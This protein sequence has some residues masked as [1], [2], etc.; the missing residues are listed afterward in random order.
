VAEAA[1]ALRQLRREIMQANGW[2]LRELYKSL[3]AP[4]ENRLRDA[5]DALDT[6]I[7]RTDG[8]NSDENILFFLLK[9][10]L[11]FVTREAKGEPI[12][13]PGLPGFV[14]PQKI[15]SAG[16]VFAS[17][18]EPAA[19]PLR[20]RGCAST[21]ESGGGMANSK[22]KCRTL[23]FVTSDGSPRQQTVQ[24]SVRW[25]KRNVLTS[26]S[27]GVGRPLPAANADS[28][29][30]GVTRPVEIRTPPKKERPWQ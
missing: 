9:L 25:E 28:G 17:E 10:N 21:K 15:S 19:P 26:K 18:P 13:P 6:A 16:I 24:I 14:A 30:H 8:M 12:A 5:H 23:R 7:P 11:E 29:A 22:L 27:G 4:G 20:E 3:E 2:S 1:R